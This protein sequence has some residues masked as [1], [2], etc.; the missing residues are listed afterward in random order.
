VLPNGLRLI[1]QPEHVGHTISVFGQVRQ[2]A[3]MQEAPGHEGVAELVNALFSYGTKSLDRLSFQKALDDIA[4]Q[5]TAGSGFSLKV[6][7]P[8][9]EAGMKLLADNELRPAFPPDAVAVVRQQTAEGLAGLL[10]SPDY[11]FG[12]A[13]K[14]AVA[15]AGDPSLRQATPQ[16]VMAL[17]LSDLEAFYRAAYRPDLTT[18]V[19]AGDVTPERARQ[20]VEQA[21]GGWTAD[22]KAPNIDLP[23]VPPSGPSAAEIPDP[24]SVQDTVTLA[25][26][27]A[28]PVSDPG[29]FT[30]MLGNTILGGGFFSRLYGDLRVRTGYVYSV[31]SALSW[32]RTRSDYTVSFGCDPQNVD[33][34]RA[35]I[36]RDVKSMQTAP[37]SD[38]ELN[39]AKAQMLRHI[40]MQLASI[41]SIAG[42]YLRLEDLG[43]P[44]NTLETGAKRIFVAT[45]ADIQAAF[46][47][48]LRPDDLAQV[49]KGPPPSR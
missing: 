28:V 49:V 35:L 14:Q 6:L 23:K 44:L 33:R 34:A 36:V 8:Q 45:P 15:P 25:E 38:T 30:L 32:H 11:L 10:Q 12:R 27:V 41:D 13:L 19:V 18:I 16:S 47:T 31:D 21:F 22:G 46:K 26:T 20:V 1:V 40:P 3:D 43:L 9:F 17:K 24:Q 4:A 7:T 29:R 42:T 39:R 48:D 2:V 37:V 5:E